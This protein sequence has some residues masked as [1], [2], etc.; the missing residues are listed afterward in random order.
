MN[1]I[2]TQYT[3]E[4][5]SLDIYLAGC[6]GNPHC[7]NC[8]NQETWDFNQGMYYKDVFNI[9][10]NKIIDFDNMIDNIMIFGGEPLDQ[11]IDKLIDLFL[12]LHSFNKQ[13]WLFT[14]Y[15]INN[16]SKNIKIYCHYVKTGRYIEE[17]KCDDNIQYGIKLA[18]SN[19][20]IHK[21]R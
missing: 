5:K 9:I 1:I 12:F 3:L 15:E 6:S 7:I 19:Q 10:K 16:V 2:S 20:K 13:I 17:L 8:H 18:T 11:E 14:R 4:H 21:I